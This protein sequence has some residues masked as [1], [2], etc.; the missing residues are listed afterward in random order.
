MDIKTIKTIFLYILFFLIFSFL[1]KITSKYIKNPIRKTNAIRIGGII[2]LREMVIIPPISFALWYYLSKRN[3]RDTNIY[4]M[5]IESIGMMFLT[6]FIV[7]YIF[8][9]R[10]R[11]GY[12]LGITKKPNGTGIAPYSN[13]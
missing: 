3:T 10:S 6:G 7:H 13:Y 1:L 4:V 9:I 11:L 5:I 12:E 8:G 2:P